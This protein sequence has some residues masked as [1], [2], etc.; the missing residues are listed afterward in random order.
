MTDLELHKLLEEA[1]QNTETADYSYGKIVG[2]KIR[3]ECNKLTD[4][5]R[6]ILMC[7]ALKLI[8]S[9]E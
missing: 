1:R 5:D 6:E 3:E 4:E 7:H 8:Y 2:A 9:K